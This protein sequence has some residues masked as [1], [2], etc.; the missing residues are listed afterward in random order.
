MSKRPESKIR[1]ILKAM[2]FDLQSPNPFKTHDEKLAIIDGYVHDLVGILG[3]GECEF[4]LNADMNAFRCSSCGYKLPKG[5][6]LGD[7]RFCGGCGKA[8]KR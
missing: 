3:G 6:N 7:T 4:E 1:M 8:V 5:T 2:A